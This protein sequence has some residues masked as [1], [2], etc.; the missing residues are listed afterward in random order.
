[1]EF[2]A[3][4]IEEAAA[5]YRRIENF[6]ERATELLGE[7]EPGDVSTEFAAALDDDLGTPQAT[8]AVHQGVRDGNNALTSGD[9]LAARRALGSVLTMTRLL[10]IAPDQWQSGSAADLSGAVD[11]LVRMALEQRTAARARKDYATADA[12][13]DQLTAAGV[14]VE[15]TPD[16]PR[17]T[18]GS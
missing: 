12:I 1:M 6:V 5:A 18:V 14:T 3:D 15:D 4:A 7:V 13:R 17:W 2:S 11:A 9:K 10:G 16:G 8:A